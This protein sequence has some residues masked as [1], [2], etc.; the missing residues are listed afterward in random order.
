MLNRLS[1]F[2][3]LLIVF[4]NAGCKQEQRPAYETPTATPRGVVAM[5]AGE[6]ANLIPAA[7]E[8]NTAR[9]KEL[10]DQGAD[11]NVRGADGRT[12]LMEAAYAGHRE[13]FRLL[14]DKG[15]RVNLKKDDGATAISFA[16]GRN[17]PVIL[18]MLVQ[19]DH[20]M[21]AAGKGDVDA[22]RK[23]LEK[24]A[25]VNARG[26]DGRTALMEAAYGGH[27]D[28]VRLLL[29]KGAD[30]KAKKD[31]GADA[32]SL[33]KPGATEIREMLKERSGD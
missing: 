15:A 21:E 10:L 31:D 6:S 25:S 27:K 11:P 4:L 1:F 5:P 16:R 28:I 2:T 18:E 24:G 17:D 20:L 26:A 23:L 7:A 22:V 33:T 19:I 13:I 30:V 3:L 12:P 9:V 29:D 8:G 32:L 14:L